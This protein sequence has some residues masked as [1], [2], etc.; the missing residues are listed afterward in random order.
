MVRAGLAVAMLF[1]GAAQ[2]SERI[3][4]APWATRLPKHFVAQG[5]K[6]EPTYEEAVDIARDGDVFSVTGGAPGWAERL[7]E[8]VEVSPMGVVSR[9]PCASAADCHEARPPSGFLATAALVAAARRGALKGT[10][11]TAAFGPWRV[12]CVDAVKLG[13]AEPILDPCFEIRTGAAIAQRHRRD[14]RFEGPTLDP[15]SLRLE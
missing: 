12:V 8:S 3:A 1:C 4:L 10:G 6:T 14:G 13:Y 9:R 5:V 7:T 11:G 2:A 15:H